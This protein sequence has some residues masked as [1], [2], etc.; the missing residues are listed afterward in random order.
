[1]SDE[2]RVIKHEEQREAAGLPG[3]A[4]T[5]T[6]ARAIRS[7][8][9]KTPRPRWCRTF[10]ITGAIT[11]VAALLAGYLLAA[12]TAAPLR[13]IAATATD[14]RRR[15]PDPTASAPTPRRRSSYG[16]SPT[17]LTTCSTASTTPSRASATSS[18]TPPMSFA[19]ADRD[20]RPD[21]GVG[22][23][24]PIAPEEVRRVEARD[25][26]RDGPNRAPGRR[27]ADPGPP[28][29]GRAA[30][31]PRDPALA[32]PAAPRRGESLGERRGRRAG[33]RH[34]ARRSRPADPG[35]SQPARQRPPPRRP[36]GRSRSPPWRAARG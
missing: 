29:R 22:P 5:R 33:G 12:R 36:G 6:G 3:A 21:R 35:A 32:L 24:R 34:P 10:L 20:S 8:R 31:A 7:R 2:S 4:A 15:R 30:Q 16:P 17:P 19:P 27:P 1:M 25:A 23:Q 18:P 11:L 28:R 9:S 13:R 26:D 14:G